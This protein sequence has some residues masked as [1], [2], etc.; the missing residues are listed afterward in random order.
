MYSKIMLNKNHNLM[1]DAGIIVLS[2]TM[3]FVMVRTGI[4]HNLLGSAVEAKIIGSFL[5][6]MFFVSFFTAAPA[7]TVLVEIAQNNS[8]FLV[9][10]FGGLGALV[11]DLIIFRFVRD[12]LSSS[13]L[14]LFKEKENRFV[15]LFRRKIFRVI[16]PFLGALIIMSP[17]P[18]EIGLMMMGLSRLKIHFFIPLAFLLNFLGILAIAFVVK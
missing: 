1:R 8:I 17:F 18:D 2:I 14:D 16:G 5:S 6:G 9:A 13:I 7:F 11:G 15:R 12:S 3:A 4:L 10:F